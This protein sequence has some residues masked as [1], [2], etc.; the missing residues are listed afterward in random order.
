[1]KFDFKGST[2]NRSVGFKDG[3]YKFWYQ[4]FNQQKVMKDLNYIEIN[5]DF[6][7]QIMQLSQD[8]QDLLQS[9][10]KKDS[11]F[12]KNHNLMDYSLLLVIE[13]VP[14]DVIYGKP[15]GS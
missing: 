10:I 1:M 6:D 12:L 15:R 3:E 2:I 11:E 9:I 14:K 8:Q 7:N 13:F 4:N 5:K